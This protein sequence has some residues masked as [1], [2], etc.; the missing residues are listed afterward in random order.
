MDP[1][2]PS[3]RPS[4]FAKPEPSDEHHTPEPER[5][6]TLPRERPIGSYLPDPEP[7]RQS[8]PSRRL[9]LSLGAGGLLL[10]VIG[11]F[12]AGSLIGPDDAA[13]GAESPSASPT[14]STSIVPTPTPESSVSA[15]PSPTPAPTPSPTPAGPPQDVAVGSWASVTVDELSVRSAAGTNAASNYILVKGAVVHVAEAAV[16]DGL[17]WYRIASLGGAS[18]WATSG[19]V[20][21]PF[22]TTLVEDPTLIRCGEIKRAVFD[23]VNGAPEPHDP[24]AIGDLS[25]PVAAFSNF[26]LGAL[27][28]MRGV[29]TEACVTAQLN[30]AGTPI[31]SAQIGVTGCGRVVRDG[32]FF[33]LRPA[34]GQNVYVDAQVKDPVVVHPALLTSTVPN[35]P[36][37]ANL[38]NV[39]LLIAERDD[40]TGCIHAN[41]QEDADGVN[42]SS[43]V[44]TTQC[45]IV[46][47]HAT[48][49]ITL[50]AAAGGDSKRVLVSEGSMQPFTVELGVPVSLQ[51]NASTSSEYGSSAWVYG[52]YYSSACE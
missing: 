29:G 3:Q 23:I 41:V 11:G 9:L 7:V 28:L 37:S 45:F 31:V 39:A 18:G 13:I 10:L 36:M 44:D 5:P 22:M 27:E 2:D 1:Q 20:A 49:G 15:S 30:A 40:T 50:G 26:T 19:W 48:D 21:E 17:N 4:I 33:R 38:R 34:A 14:V 6:R 35:D 32:A 52:S 47:E 8:G 46:Y 42:E 51:V 16:V 43:S 25:L 12:V 24:L